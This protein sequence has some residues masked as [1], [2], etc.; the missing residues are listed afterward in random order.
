MPVFHTGVQIPTPVPDMLPA[1][2]DPGESG[3]DGSLQAFRERTSRWECDVC[4]RTGRKENLHTD[5]HTGWGEASPT[6]PM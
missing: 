3:S 2:A 1:N 4:V 5:A 6:G